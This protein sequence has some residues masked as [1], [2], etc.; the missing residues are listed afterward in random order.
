MRESKVA[1]TTKWARKTIKQ[2][3]SESGKEW[4]QNKSAVSY[5][6]VKNGWKRRKSQHRDPQSDPEN[7]DGMINKFKE[8]LLALI[9]EHDLKKKKIFI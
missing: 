2:I 4:Y 9:K 7:K 8:D 6:F 5:M 1:V 3:I